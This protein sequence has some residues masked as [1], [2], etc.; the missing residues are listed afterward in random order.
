MAQSR[1]SISILYSA[2]KLADVIVGRNNFEMLI[3]SVIPAPSPRIVENF[4]KTKMYVAQ[5]L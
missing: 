2:C 1:L 5:V 3:G 4:G